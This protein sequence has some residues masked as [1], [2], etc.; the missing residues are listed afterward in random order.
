MS[1]NNT[2]SERLDAETSVDE[3]VYA[4]NSGVR[5][6]RKRVITYQEL[7]YVG[8][9]LPGA[10]TQAAYLR[11]DRTA[12]WSQIKVVRVGKTQFQTQAVKKTVSDWGNWENF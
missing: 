10:R 6:R 9:N 1:W 2:G 12:T 11:A 3:Y 4:L 7:A 8:M 5:Q